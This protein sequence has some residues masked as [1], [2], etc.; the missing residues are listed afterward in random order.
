MDV[1]SIWNSNFITETILEIML[2]SATSD[3]DTKIYGH[4]QAGLPSSYSLPDFGHY[5]EKTNLKI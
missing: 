2:N 4:G 1:L 5:A 3:G